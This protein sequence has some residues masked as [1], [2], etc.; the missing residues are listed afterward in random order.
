MAAQRSANQGASAHPDLEALL[1]KARAVKVTEEMLKE[2]AVSFIYG[3]APQ[4]SKITKESARSAVDRR[5]LT[6]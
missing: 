4:G 3:N 6:R 2:Q 5:L 1:E